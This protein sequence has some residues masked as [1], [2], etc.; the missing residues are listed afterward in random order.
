MSMRNCSKCGRPVKGHPGQCGD[1]CQV[2]SDEEISREDE[3]AAMATGGEDVH[4]Y[5]ETDKHVPPSENHTINELSFQVSNLTVEV[6]ALAK[7]N[8]DILQFLMKTSLVGDPTQPPVLGDPSDDRTRRPRLSM[9]TLSGVSAIPG[10]TLAQSSSQSRTH[11]LEGG[12]KIPE[13]TYRNA[14]SGEYINLV[15]FLPYTEHRDLEANII[16]GEL[17]FRPKKSKRSL[18]NFDLWL[19]AWSEYEALLVSARPHIYANLSSYRRFIQASD[20]KYNWHAVLSYDLRYR[21]DLARTRSFNYSKL[22]NDLVVSILDATAVK[23]D[24]HRCYRCRSVEHVV[25]ECPFPAAHKMET[26]S[27]EKKSY[28]QF[29]PW[30]HQGKEG[31]NNFN[32][33]KCNFSQCNR[34]HVC[35]GCRSADPFIKCAQCN[36][37]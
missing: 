22:N 5:E 8:N 6:K 33:G 4:V 36:K 2:D 13:T 14:V 3:K 19:Q 18:D 26:N 30:Y 34:A 23:S 9:P 29:K 31:C 32:Y 7:Q 21:T 10:P 15:D 35:K 16:N 25:Q 28:K 20:R 24:L 27:K 11:Y 37:G 12:A 17:Q 1:K